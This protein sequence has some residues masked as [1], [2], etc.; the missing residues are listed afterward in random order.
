MGSPL[1]MLPSSKEKYTYF[2]ALTGENHLG[3]WLGIL[4]LATRA[5]QIG[6]QEVE[7]CNCLNVNWV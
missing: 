5:D 3:R 1:T 7:E 2:N 6:A 4:T